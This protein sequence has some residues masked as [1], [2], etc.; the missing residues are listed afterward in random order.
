MA[1][2]SGYELFSI[3][4]N[5]LTELSAEDESIITGGGGSCYGGSKSK[6]KKSKSKKSKSKS[7]KYC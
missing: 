3:S 1:N 6:S 5:F 7:K 4:E 2:A